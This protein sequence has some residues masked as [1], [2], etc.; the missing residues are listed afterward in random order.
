MQEAKGL[1]FKAGQA[2]R[3]PLKIL[4]QLCQELGAGGP[5][6]DRAVIPIRQLHGTLIKVPPGYVHLVHNLA[7]SVKVAWDVYNAESFYLYLKA[8]CIANGMQYFGNANANDYM[9]V[10]SVV[11]D[12]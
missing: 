5:G 3:P 6:K 4:L 11:I 9:A 7:P 1:S 12:L 10:P 2:N 8:Q